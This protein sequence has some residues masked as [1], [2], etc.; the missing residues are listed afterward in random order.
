MVKL[1]AT[2]ADPLSE[3]AHLHQSADKLRNALVEQ[4]IGRHRQLG[5]VLP[6]QVEAAL[7]KVPRHLFTPGVSLQAAYGL[8]SVI[9]K[10]DEHGVML[11]TVSAPPTIAMMLGQAGELRG[12]RILEI[13][14]GGYNAALLRELV[15]PDGSVTT[16]DIDQEVVDRTRSCLATAGYDDVRVALHGRGVR[17]RRVRPVGSDHCHRRSVGHPTGVDGAARRGWAT[18]GSV[19]HDRPDPIL[20]F[21]V[22]RR[23][24]A[25]PESPTVRVRPDAGCWGAPRT[26]DPSARRRGRPVGGR[27]TARRPRLAE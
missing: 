19:A 1:I 26:R 12:R 16:I 11:S 8:D 9:T 25:E 18:R 24:F 4:I 7:R 5:L 27:G 21:H 14:S 17:R 10:R 23:T 6:F 2:N 13:G 22:L 20:G 15:G 3:E